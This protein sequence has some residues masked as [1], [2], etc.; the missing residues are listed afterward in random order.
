MPIICTSR[1]SRSADTRRAHQRHAVFFA[2]GLEHQAPPEQGYAVVHDTPFAGINAMAVPVRN[3][4][5]AVV[6]ALS[7][8]GASGRF[9]PEV[10]RVATLHTAERLTQH[11]TLG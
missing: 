7:L 5:G 11:L 10:H 8:A 2:G 9:Q 1:P 6:A 4:T 3:R